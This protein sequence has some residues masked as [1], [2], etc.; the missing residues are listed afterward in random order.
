MISLTVNSAEAHS[1]SRRSL[2]GSAAARN[3]VRKVSMAV[4]ALLV[5][6]ETERVRDETGGNGKI[7]IH[8]NVTDRYKHIF[9]FVQFCWQ[10]VHWMKVRCLKKVAIYGELLV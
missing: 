1:D 4:R 8:L 6:G 2:V 5:R 10:A 3:L 9:M 7:V